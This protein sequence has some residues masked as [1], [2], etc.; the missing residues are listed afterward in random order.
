MRI[1]FRAPAGST[2]AVGL[3]VEEALHRVRTETGL[4]L[5]GARARLGFSRGHLLELVLLSSAFGSAADERALTAA[6]LL[7][8]YLIGEAAFDDWV[9]AIEVG[10]AARAKSLRVLPDGAFPP[11]PTLALDDIA[12]AVEAAIRGVTAGLPATP[13][14]A[15]AEREEWTLLEAEPALASDYAAQDDLVLCSTLLPEAIKCFLQGSPFSSCRFSK[16]GERFVYAK[17]DGADRTMEARYALRVSL[18]EAIEEALLPPGLG[19]VVGAGIGVRYVY[20]VIALASPEA[21]LV[22]TCQALRKLEVPQRA[23]ILP[24]DSAHEGEWAPV[25]DDAPE[26]PRA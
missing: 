2:K 19:C 11:D 13:Y 17:V 25:W 12:P 5:D 24:C 10:P 3:S 9:G 22:T 1:R 16:H 6:N 26:P 8:P 14:H 23:W 15:L 18:E 4:D 20:V 7:V 21:A